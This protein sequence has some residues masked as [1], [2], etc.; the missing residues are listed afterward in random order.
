[1]AGS[2]IK[3]LLSGFQSE[4]RLAVV[5]MDLQAGF[6]G[7]PLHIHEDWDETFYVLAG[8]VTFQIDDEVATAKQGMLAFASRHTPH[9]LANLSGADARI[10]IILTPAGFEEYLSTRAGSHSPL[11]STR[12]VAPLIQ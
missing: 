10:L 9:T 2:P 12:A 6:R 7:P 5:A 11:P 8:E 3:V 4:G 1:M